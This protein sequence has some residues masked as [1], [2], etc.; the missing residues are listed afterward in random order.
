MYGFIDPAVAI[1]ILVR[2]WLTFLSE[3]AV[4]VLVVYEANGSSRKLSAFSS[5]LAAGSLRDNS[6]LWCLPFYLWA[7]QANLLVAGLFSDREGLAYSSRVH[8]DMEG[9]FVSLFYLLAF[10]TI[11][12]VMTNDAPTTLGLTGHPRTAVT[13]AVL[14]VFLNIGLFFWVL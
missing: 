14:S 6:G 12:T 7:W 10:R 2:F 1:W 8:D 13:A 3:L 9:I 4:V 5:R 11:G